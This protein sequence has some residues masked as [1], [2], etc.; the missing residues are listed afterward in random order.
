MH[1]IDW[2]KIQWNNNQKQLNINS[3]ENQEVILPI[4][5][6]DV[7]DTLLDTSE[8]QMILIKELLNNS[9]KTKDIES[10]QIWKDWVLK[11]R[12]ILFDNALDFI[13]TA[14]QNHILFVFVSN[15]KHEVVEDTKNNLFNQQIP[16]EL[17]NK[18]WLWWFKEKPVNDTTLISKEERINYLENET[19]QINFDNQSVKAKFQIIMR[20]GDQFTDFNSNLWQFTNLN[21][22][23]TY[24]HD[25]NINNLFTNWSSKVVFKKNDNDQLVKHYFDCDNNTLFDQRTLKHLV[26]GFQK[27][28]KCKKEWYLFIS[29][30]I[31]YGSW[32][33]NFKQRKNQVKKNLQL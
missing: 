19:H 2:N 28:K 11:K 30:N 16:Y 31:A 6:S 33:H 21:D 9:E 32:F 1:Y 25:T 26:I 13:K 14:Y 24:L 17:L 27:V 8:F 12:G 15:R 29:G 10:S 23:N 4:I 5:V 20:I 18:D 22:N 7:D 3:S